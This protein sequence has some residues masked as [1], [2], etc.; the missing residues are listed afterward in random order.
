MT[1]MSAYLRAKADRCRRLAEEADG[2][3]IRALHEMA[4]EFEAKATELERPDP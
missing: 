2:W 3:V 4:D 1:L